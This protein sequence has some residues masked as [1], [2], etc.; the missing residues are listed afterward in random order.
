MGGLFP[1]TCARGL[2]RLSWSSP[3][4]EQVSERD[5]FEHVVAGEEFENPASRANLVELPLLLGDLDVA[6]YK[7]LDISCSLRIFWK[8]GKHYDLPDAEPHLGSCGLRIGLDEG[9]LL[10]ERLG[11]SGISEVSTTGSGIGSMSVA[12]FV[13]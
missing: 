7:G 5:F 1:P 9:S 13:R 8:S 4:A 10:E 6:P 2:V 12:G 3:F 11:V